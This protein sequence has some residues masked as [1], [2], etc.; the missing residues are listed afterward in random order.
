M[1]EVQQ[2]HK[3]YKEKIVLENVSFDLKSGEIVGLVGENG[4]G[5]STLLQLLATVMQ[6]TEGEIRLNGLS[7]QNNTKEI[8]QEIGYVPQ[9]I[10]DLGRIHRRR[11]YVVLLKNCPGKIERESNAAKFAWTC[12]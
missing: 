4:A 1:L 5:K 11:E 8:R 9:D 3:K 12:N 10:L 7:Y 2:L 6:P